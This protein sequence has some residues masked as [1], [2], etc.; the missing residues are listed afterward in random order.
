M[1][2]LIA[3]LVPFL[4]SARADITPA[5]SPHF[6][7]L[8]N[9]AP[10]A[11]SVV[12][13]AKAAQPR[14]TGDG[15]QVDT[16]HREE[17][18]LFFN[19]VFFSTE[20]VP[21]Q[22]TGDF[23]TGNPGTTAADFKEANRTRM[24]FLRAMAGVPAW[25]VYDDTLSAKCQQMALMISENGALSHHPPTT[26]LFYTADGAEAAA[27]GNL[28]LGSYGSEAL[29]NLLR[30]PGAGNEVLGHRR[31]MLYP[32]TK[33]M[34][35][36]DVPRQS[37]FN[38]AHVSWVFDDNFGGP[39]PTVRDDFVAWP[40]KGFVPYQLFFPRWSFAYPN[41]DFSAATVTMSRDGSPLPVKQETPV[42]GFGENTIVWV[43]NNLDDNDF[44]ATFGPAPDHDTTYH[45]TVG[46]VRIAG[47]PRAFT[48]DVIAF[49]PA[50][51]GADTALPTVQNAGNLQVGKGNTI[52]FTRMPQAEGYR[53]TVSTL[54]PASE[55]VGAEQGLD[56]LTAATSPG[57]NAVDTLLAATGA[58]SFHLVQPD[59]GDQTLQLTGRYLPGSDGHITFNSRLGLATDTQIARVQVSTDGLTWTDL[60]TQ[61]GANGLGETKF[62][63]VTLSLAAYANQLLQ[64]RFAYTFGGGNAFTQ[65]DT[66]AGWHVDDIAFTG[67]RRIVATATSDIPANGSISY[68]PLTVGDYLFQ[69]IPELYSRYNVPGPA[70][71][72]TATAGSVPALA[73]HLGHP[74]L[75]GNGAV[76]FSVTGDTTSTYIV[77]VSGNLHD[78]TTLT[79]LPSGPG[80]WTVLDK[81]AGKASLFYRVRGQ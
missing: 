80:S 17:S 47:V 53:W 23:L 16:S 35:T 64:F 24:N 4:W 19:E 31:W 7:A 12:V 59:F 52:D 78:W 79:N 72:L 18:R 2:L 73:A 20:N 63:P 77:E 10:V 69:I 38:A 3:G 25:I 76:Q 8:I 37:Q 22:W 6:P 34:G 48:Y 70:K 67:T 33:I 26:W 29:Y 39:R 60:F 58:A 81:I 30:D 21:I 66:I 50:V 61:P 41:A 40:P 74:S 13:P 5:P 43:P 54:A 57:Y 11:P 9:E 49:D 32:Q 36:G 56:G 44:D 68:N 46:N 1:D 42:N 62:R 15:F 71:I 55:I 75:S 45:V 14:L 51:P 65:V 28:A 27:N